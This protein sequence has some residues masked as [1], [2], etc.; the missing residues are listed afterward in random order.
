VTLLGA[1]FVR[2]V[3]RFAQET[4]MIFV[5]ALEVTPRLLPISA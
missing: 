1:D 2:C 3:E 4:R 5:M